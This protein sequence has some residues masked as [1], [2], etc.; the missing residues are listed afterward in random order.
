MEELLKRTATVVDPTMLKQATT[1][2]DALASGTTT[3]FTT[4]QA[5]AA[6]L[7]PKL[8]SAQNTVETALLA[9]APPTHFMSHP[10][11]FNWLCSQVSSSWPL[12]GSAMVPAPRLGWC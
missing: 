11:R 5:T 3:A 6:L 8:F 10:R 9:Q 7:W 4:T 1:G 2:V 12:M